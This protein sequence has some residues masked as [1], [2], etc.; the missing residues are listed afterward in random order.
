MPETHLYKETPG[1]PIHLDVYPP[2][3]ATKPYPAVIWVHGGALIGG[4][5]AYQ[6]MRMSQYA[7]RGYALVAIDYR[8]APETKL[9][10]IVADVQD[11]L[12]WVR[13]KGPKVADLDPERVGMVGHS[14]GGY[15]ALMAGTF[16]NP[17][18]A[19]VSFYGYGDIVGPWYSEPDPG[20]CKFP[21]VSEEEA[22]RNHS[23]PPISRSEDRPN[24]GAG[25]F[26]LYCRQQGIWPNEVGG[27]DPKEDPAFFVP[28]CPEQNVTASYPPTM[29]LHGTNDSDVPYVLSAQMAAALKKKG[30]EHQLVTI[31]D[32]EHGFDHRQDRLPPPW[33]DAVFAFLDRQLR[34]A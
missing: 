18:K 19:L 29:L 26:Y 23:G 16:T 11:A 27:R 24:H 2:A 34:D 6:E 9:P 3:N 7:P 22:R 30:I 28:Y 12:N 14:A 17:P 10:E 8:L 32:G 33:Q 15:L 1:C 13:Q 25:N 21:M 20:Y 4:S 31:E 5:R